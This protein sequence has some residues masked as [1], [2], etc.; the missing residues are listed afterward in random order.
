MH[1]ANNLSFTEIWSLPDDAWIPP[2]PASTLTQISESRLAQL[3]SMGDGPPY[4]KRGN[5]VR[6]NVGKIKNWLAG[7]PAAA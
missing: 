6:Y 3:R 4:T 7:N 2:K 1:P 5:I